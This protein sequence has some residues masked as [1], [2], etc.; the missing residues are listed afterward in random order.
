MA[1]ADLASKV[2]AVT[3][4][5]VTYEVGTNDVT[6]TIRYAAG[7]PALVVSMPHHEGSLVSKGTSLGSYDSVYGKLELYATETLAW[8]AKRWDIRTALDL[9]KLSSDQKGK[10]ATQVAADVAA[11]KPY[12]QDTYFGGKG[13][14]RDAMLMEIAKAVGAQDAAKTVK[15]RLT[16]ALQKWTEPKGADARATECFVYDPKYHG[17]IGLAASFGSDEYNDHHFHY[18]YFLYAAGVLCAD[19]SALAAKLAPVM[20]LLAA[21]IASPTDTGFF[22]QWRPFDAYASHSWASGTSPFADGNNQESSSEAVNAWAGLALWARARGDKALEQQATWM[23]SLEAQTALAYWL[24]PD[25]SAFSGFQHHIV[26]MCWGTKRD[27]STWFSADPTAILMI[28]VLPA[29]PSAGYLAAS[30]DRVSAAI[31]EAVGSGDYSKTYGDYCL[32]YSSLASKDAAA[33]ALDIAPRLAD[34]IDDGS[35]MSYLLAYLMTR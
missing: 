4:T 22:P 27:Y 11:T 6:T 10:L 34:H 1:V 21:D 32:L 19:D 28:Q 15:D 29:G 18:G 8:H 30:P 7:G 13:L 23:H 2:Q 20:D 16:T 26:G 24:A 3:G 17:M 25:M 14:Y 5:D 33:K 35:S 31:T 9:S 12:P